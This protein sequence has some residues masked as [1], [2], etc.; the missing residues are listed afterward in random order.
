[1]TAQQ[2]TLISAWSGFAYRLCGFLVG[3]FRKMESFDG[4]FHRL[5]G[6]LVSRLVVFFAVMDSGGAV[7]MCGQIVELRCS[8]V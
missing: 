5:L 8:S 3:F 6:M 1:V 7:R 2:V 4:M